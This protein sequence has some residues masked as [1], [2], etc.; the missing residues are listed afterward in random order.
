MRVFDLI[1]LLAEED[2]DTEVLICSERD[3]STWHEIEYYSREQ[4]ITQLPANRVIL[5]RHKKVK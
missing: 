3:Q 1:N 4:G 5:I 2:P